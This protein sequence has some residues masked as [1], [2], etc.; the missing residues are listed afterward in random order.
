MCT[1]DDGRKLTKSYGCHVIGTLDLRTLAESLS[2]PAPLS[3]SA[4]CEYYL[5][6]AME[7]DVEVRCSDWSADTLTDDQITYAS[8]DALIPTIIYQKVIKENLLC[9]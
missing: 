9:S 4:L 6:F 1:Y 3:L 2:L 7:K 5:G 8:Y